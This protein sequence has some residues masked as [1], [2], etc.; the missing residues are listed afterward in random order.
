MHAHFVPLTGEI[1]LKKILIVSE[2]VHSFLHF[3]VLF[4]LKHITFAITGWTSKFYFIGDVLSSL[5]SYYTTKKNKILV[6]I[7]LLLHAPAIFHLFD[8]YPTVFYK[9]VFKIASNNISNVSNEHYYLYNI[10]TVLDICC[11]LYN[12]KF[13][14]QNN[15]KIM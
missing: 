1:L 5:L 3:I 12:V 8:I 14:Y 4:N 10:G 2:L 6:V 11:H 13:L 7:H 15:K 9:N